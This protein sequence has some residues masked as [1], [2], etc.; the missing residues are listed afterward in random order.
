MWARVKGRTEN[1]LLRLPLKAYMFRPGLIEPMDGI[2]SKTPAYR[3]LYGLTKPLL[4]LLH[5]ALP[6]QV[7]TTREIGQ[8]MLAVARKGYAKQVMETRDIRAVLK[9][10]E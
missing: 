8:A 7:L 9:G 1:A 4:P 10:S 5:W 3:V 2:R 6:N